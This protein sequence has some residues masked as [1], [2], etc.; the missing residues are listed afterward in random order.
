M[1]SA[2]EATPN[3]FAAF[4]QRETSA[5]LYQCMLLDVFVY[6]LRGARDAK[7]RTPPCVHIMHLSYA[8]E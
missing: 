5:L 8:V 6:A 3:G 4:L 2:V 1:G 7:M